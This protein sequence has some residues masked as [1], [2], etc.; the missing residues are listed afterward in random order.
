LFD[1]EEW[2][3]KYSAIAGDYEKAFEKLLAIRL[4]ENIKI[5]R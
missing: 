4:I 3:D 5:V 1:I 2:L